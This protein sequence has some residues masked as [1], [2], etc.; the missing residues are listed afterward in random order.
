MPFVK[1]PNGLV[2]EMGEGTAADLVG[3][4]SGDYEYVEVS[5][6][7]PKKTAPKPSFKK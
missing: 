4:P 7:E 6:P 3:S 5:K 2:I 1:G